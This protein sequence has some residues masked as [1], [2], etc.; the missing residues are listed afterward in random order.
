MRSYISK[1]TYVYD[2]RYCCGSNVYVNTSAYAHICSMQGAERG[3]GCG[4]PSENAS[5]RARKAA[6][7]AR[8]L[9]LAFLR[10]WRS[11]QWERSTPQRMPCERNIGATADARAALSL[12]YRTHL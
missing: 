3:S 6:S 8:R 9:A 4:N 1:E 11:G 10:G 2:S 5:Q 12:R 7:R